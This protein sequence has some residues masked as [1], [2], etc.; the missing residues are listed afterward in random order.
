M[1][2]KWPKMGVQRCVTLRAAFS[3]LFKTPKKPGK[4]RWVLGK[5]TKLGKMT[6]SED[7]ILAKI[8]QNDAFSDHKN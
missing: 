4:L 5:S 1:V 7:P 3:Y 2:Q 6:P 8:N